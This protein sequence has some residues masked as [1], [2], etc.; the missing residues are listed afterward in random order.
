MK[1]NLLTF[2][3]V[4]LKNGMNLGSGSKK[5][6][7]RLG[8]M[9]ILVICFIPL[10][11]M[12][13]GFVANVYDALA[14][15]GQAGVIITSGIGV[16]ALVIFVFGIFYVINVFYFSEDVEN[17]LPLPLKPFHILGAK[18]TV[19]TLY[20]YITAGMI[21]WPIF[22]VFGIKSGAGP[23]YY[24][25]AALVFL[26]V[27]VIP[28]TVASIITMVIMRFTNLFRNKDMFK[29]IAGILAIAFGVGINVIIQRTVV[30]QADMAQLQD[31]LVGGENSLMTITS[32]IFPGSNWAAQGLVN[33]HTLGGALNLLLFIGISVL[34]F[35]LFLYLGEKL[36]FKGVIGLSQTASKREVLTSDQLERISM[37]RSP[38]WSYAV[39]ELRILFRTPIYFLNC[40][41]I[42]FLLPI[43]FIIPMASQ[44]QGIEGMQNA[45]SGYLKGGQVTGMALGI[46]FGA[47]LF[48]GSFNG[49]TSTAISREGHGM[50]VNKFIPLS[51]RQQILGKVIPG[52][53][54]GGA[55]MVMVVVIGA[56]ILKLPAYLAI[57][58]IPLGLMAVFFS[59]FTGMLLDIR[60]PKLNWD[61]EQQAVKQNL[62]VLLNMVICIVAA[63]ATVFIVYISNMGL[64]TAFV[65]LL[66][67]YIIIN[68]LLYRLLMNRGVRLIGQLED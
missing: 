51:Y 57:M 39:K 14:G 65:V 17:L 62:N 20:E 43:F 16:S 12:L 53:L 61:S 44:Q 4:L 54:M 48:F 28:L 25:H 68:M 24:I 23:L 9:G 10:I 8:F 3:W 18:F 49:I 27:P 35:L 38:T 50:F 64:W 1:S 59:A 6:S 37:Y 58:A 5:R 41:L 32:R 29:M 45:L 30:R 2:T 63:A 46:I 47:L 55:G 66:A 13:A 22:I 26:V 42:N 19:V 34:S 33:S 67:G 40:V 36:Y 52:V 7:S 21:L 56:V 15:I 31:L 60:N 11:S